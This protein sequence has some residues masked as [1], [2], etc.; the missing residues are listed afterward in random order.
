VK[1]GAR[2]SALY[3]YPV[4]A[5]AGVAV[6][7]AR[8]VERGFEYDRRYM[9]VDEDGDFVTQRELPELALVTT[10]LEP[11]G[12]VLGR[13]GHESCRL[14]LSLG[15]GDRLDVRVWGHTGVAVRHVAASAW[16]SNVLAR[17]VSVVYM[18]D[19]H[20]RQVN[21]ERARPGDVVSF[22]DA[23][24]F[25]VISE[26]SLEDLNSRLAE[27]LEMRRFRPNIVVSGVAAYAEDGFTAIRLGALGFRGPKRCDRCAVT[28]V[29]PKTGVRGVEPLRTLAAYRREDGKVWFGMNLIHDDQGLLSIGDPL[30]FA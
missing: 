25:L 11:D 28:T 8:V 3:V 7:S 9:I 29:D 18:P 27:P 14:P 26:A 21:P 20:R 4:K 22:A 17:P 13:E 2:I 16:M 19:D 15:H 10:A 23:F 5:C 1:S 12:I 24:P 30:I 6:A